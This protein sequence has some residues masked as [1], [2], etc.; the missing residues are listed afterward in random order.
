MRK[1]KR[2]KSTRAFS[3]GYQFGVNGKSK[4][5]CPHND[6]DTRQ[7]WLSGWRNGREDN[8]DG[9]TGTAGVCRA[10]AM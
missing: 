5:R 7:S 2:D 9:F 8:W 6:A 3:R 10:P 4:E 1:L